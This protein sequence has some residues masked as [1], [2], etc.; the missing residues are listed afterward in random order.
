MTKL[1]FGLTISAPVLEWNIIC[2]A[3]WRWGLQP[4]SWQRAG[5]PSFSVWVSEKLET[6]CYDVRM[7][8]CL[9]HHGCGDRAGEFLLR[10]S[11]S[12]LVQINAVCY[13]ERRRESGI[14]L[15]VSTNPFCRN[16]KE[17]PTYY[18]EFDFTVKG[19]KRNKVLLARTIKHDSKIR[20]QRLQ[21]L[22]FSDTEYNCVK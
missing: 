22:K 1:A 15:E 20:K 5:N 9:P 14:G 21:I 16:L 13:T 6:Y 4:E 7:E 10:I 11:N 2:R 8:T 17:L 18:K 3:Y 12:E 19:C